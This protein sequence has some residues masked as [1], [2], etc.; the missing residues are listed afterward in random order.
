A[1]P[2]AKE[3]ISPTNA[4]AAVTPLQNEETV[5]KFLSKVKLFQRLPKE[6]HTTLANACVP[7]EYKPKARIISQGD[8]GDEFFLIQVGEADVEVNGKKVATLKAN[9]YFGETALL[10][11][12]PRTATIT[13]KTDLKALKLSRERFDLLGLRERLDFPQRKAVG[14]GGMNELVTKPPSSKTE[15]ERLE[16]IE[17][18]KSNDNLMSVVSLSDHNLQSMVDVAWKESSGRSQLRRGGA[19]QKSDLK[20]NG[21]MHWVP[22]LLCVA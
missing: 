12:E 21:A 2:S 17:A 3:S 13:A 6:V 22:A 19:M 9:D 11:N 15:Q 5:I 20:V 16:M 10:R 14:G 8:D 18:L 7:A 1:E 4:V